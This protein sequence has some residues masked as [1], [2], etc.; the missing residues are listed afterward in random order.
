MD[1]NSQSKT[2]LD[3]TS[4]YD[5]LQNPNKKSKLTSYSYEKTT[6]LHNSTSSSS[7]SP[8]LSFNRPKSS[9][10]SHEDSNY[11]MLNELMNSSDHFIQTTTTKTTSI[12][13]AKNDTYLNEIN[14]NNNN[15]SNN[16]K[17]V[18]L[19]NH[20]ST[21][22][23][24]LVK[25]QRYS[26]PND[27]NTLNAL[28]EHES[29]QFSSNTRIPT[30]VSQG[31]LNPLDKSSSFQRIEYGINQALSIQLNNNHSDYKFK[32]FQS[33]FEYPSQYTLNYPNI[34]TSTT[35]NNNSGTVTGDHHRHHHHHHHQSHYP[36]NSPHLHHQHPHLQ[37]EQHRQQ[38]KD[39]S[40]CSTSSP[41]QN[42]F[43]SSLPFEH[44]SRYSD[45]NNNSTN[46]TS[47]N[48]IGFIKESNR[49]NLN[50]A[51]NE[52]INHSMLNKD[53]EHLRKSIMNKTIPPLNNI[54]DNY[55]TEK[56]LTFN[57]NLN[58]TTTNNNNTPKH[59]PHLSS[60]PTTTT[61]EHLLNNR[62]IEPP[63]ASVIS[64]NLNE[65]II[66]RL[67]SHSIVTP[68]QSNH[69][70]SRTIPPS[71]PRNINECTENL[72]RLGHLNWASNNSTNNTTTNNSSHP[73]N[74]GQTGYSTEFTNTTRRRNAT[75]ESTT[76]LKAWLQEHIKN[77]YPTKGEKIMLAIITKM[78]LTQH[79]KSMIKPDLF[80]TNFHEN[81]SYNSNNN[82][83]S[84]MNMK[85]FDEFHHFPLISS[86]PTPNTSFLM[87]QIQ[88]NLN[89]TTNAN[90]TT[91][92]TA[93]TTFDSLF[94][95]Q[96]DKMNL[97]LN[98]LNTFNKN[99]C[100]PPHKAFENNNNNNTNSATTHITYQLNN[101]I[102]NHINE[103]KDKIDKKKFNNRL[104]HA[105]WTDMINP[106]SVM[107]YD[108]IPFGS[109]YGHPHPHHYNQSMSLPHYA[110]ENSQVPSYIHALNS[111]N[112]TYPVNQ[113]PM[114]DFMNASSSCSSSTVS[115]GEHTSLLMPSDTTTTGTTTTTTE[116]RAT[117]MPITPSTTS[118]SLY[119]QL[120]NFPNSIHLLSPTPFNSI[121]HNSEVV[122]IT[123]NNNMLSLTNILN[124]KE[125]LS[126]KLN[127]N[128][129]HGEASLP[130][131]L[132]T[133]NDTVTST[134]GYM[135][136]CNNNNNK[137]SFH[138]I[139]NIHNSTV[140]EATT[141]ITTMF[142][143]TASTTAGVTSPPVS[144]LNSSLWSPQLQQSIRVDE[145]NLSINSGQTKETTTTTPTTGST[146]WQSTNSSLTV[147]ISSSNNNNNNSSRQRIIPD[148]FNTSPT[149]WSDNQLLHDTYNNSEL[150]HHI[151]YQPLYNSMNTMPT[152]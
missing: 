60:I 79:N 80:K 93:N 150:N 89:A 110:Q 20:E 21:D 34:H 111:S 129:N 97:T 5:Q 88:P 68:L 70:S 17:D 33:S 146:F 9:S 145:S 119:T 106:S 23:I 74:R 11:L 75:K 91:V 28:N 43:S 52:L 135:Q 125:F 82:N 76:T 30:S 81:E 109:Y 144:T 56:L 2:L 147:P 134:L 12:N 94:N 38:I 18:C 41:L 35:I 140:S 128:E 113:L 14:N 58:N 51:Q 55:S 78:T 1:D 86:Y 59:T 4:T 101:F 77:P 96:Y 108:S 102:E 83:N 36:L 6:L 98:Q 118:N 151:F 122:S 95:E 27:L 117:E 130:A 121:D 50:S 120:C 64:N 90:T 141:R 49:L 13:D 29:E 133:P 99:Q 19:I 44:L 22:M 85:K 152:R 62:H 25:K 100:V 72:S 84:L 54:N 104:Y 31:I 42:Y 124:S 37:E 10:P 48:N 66:P 7:S 138:T 115:P 26:S 103:F 73:Y 16:M 148:D 3:M 126:P 53:I 107:K 69:S 47:N 61:N 132:L 127:R 8:S 142:T 15:N 114:T 116:T 139:D 32:E 92:A 39:Y 57:Q 67:V 112:R 143:S 123:N 24:P 87:N 136:N 46:N 45:Y 105:D 131:S 149:L 40:S 65:N 137:L 71:Y 63:F